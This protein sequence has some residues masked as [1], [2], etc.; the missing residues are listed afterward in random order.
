[1]TANQDEQEMPRRLPVD[2]EERE[3]RRFNRVMTAALCSAML[4]PAAY[5]QEAPQ[6]EEDNGDEPIIV[7]ATLR[8]MDVQDIPL[9][10]TAVAPETL[11]REGV[12]DIKTLSSISPSFN[13]QSSQTET[14]G[15]SIKIR[16]VGTTGNNTGLESSVGV[17]IDGVYQSRPGV[18]LGDLV[19]LERLEILRGPQGTLFG[20]NTSAGALNIT[21][22]RPNLSEFE[23]FVNASYGNYNFMNVQA[24]VS[25]P[26][27]QD[28]AAA[29]FSG[30]WRK[31]DGFLKSTT[32][33]ESNNRDR[34]MLRGQL[35]IEPNADVSIR[36]LGDY[37]KVDENCCDAVVMRETE[38]QPFFAFHGLASDGIDQVGRPALQ[39]LS[40]NSQL[41]INTS[42]QWG[43]SG[44]LKWDF[45]GAKLTYIGSYRDFKSESTQESD[46]T[47]LAIFT[48]GRNGQNSR[49][50]ILPN[51]DKIKTMTQELRLQGTAFDDH[52]DWLIGGFYSDEK[53]RALGSLTAGA[54]FQRAV[55]AGNFANLAGV[56]PLF[57]LTAFGNA[58][59]PVNINGGYAENLFIQNAKSFSVFTHNVINFTDRLSLTL[60]ARYVDEKKTAS[61]DQLNSTNAAC[62][63]SVTGVLNGGVP[64]PLRAGLV[65]LNCFPFIA[66]VTLTAPA[67]LGGGLA[68]R[69]LP[70][71]REWANTFKDNEITYTAQVGYKP[72]DDLLL[73]A[74]Y[75]HGF[76]SGGFNL[77]PTAANLSNST[78][79]LTT[80]AAPIYAD[81]R[82]KSE[83]VDQ[84]EAGV[85]ATIGGIK[86]NLAVFQMDMADFQVLEFTGV[87]FTTF[88]VNSAKSTGVELELFGRL[89]DHI[90]G[91]FSAT[92][93][94]ARYPKNCNVGV[95]ADVLASVTR[96][97]G[98][99]LTNAP[100][101]AG[102][103]GLTYDGPLNSSGWGL[104]VNG[105]INYSSKRRTSTLPLDNNNLPIPFDYQNAY[106]KMNAR[107]GLT[108]PDEQFTFELWGTNINNEK[109]RGITANTPLRGGVGTRSRIGF[110]EEPRM[111][112]LTV[113][114]KF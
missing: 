23:G 65:G 101:L 8:A 5:A 39:N 107:I 106:F 49:P 81:P 22:K 52:L 34:Y 33:A 47:S 4:V 94:N 91:N 27:A 17:F 59:V 76:K 46:F 77:D 44:E 71:P 72:N 41:F 83:K 84:I 95:P 96:L 63:A 62:Q 58:G 100:K 69:Y 21:T 79:V 89:S 99:S 75:S 73:Y 98:D 108:T 31:R 37:S 19:D 54:D 112:G 78:A 80:G 103:M 66:P 64:A 40:T 82:F 113:R 53:I 12:S 7:T 15:T 26:L 85:K 32:G 48:A 24:G 61:F 14:Q 68:S 11:E 42:T 36:I 2:V 90:T 55:S 86:A 92:Y 93:A 30:T 29:R 6:A 25:I 88:N 114:A 74:G 13:I 51:G 50:G 60:G 38:L 16:G 20:R 70:L 35:Y 104:L 45:G 102:V 18:A 105:S 3:M 87:Q 97:C 109:T 110:V 43:M 9:A 67:A 10:V 111:Y 28:V 57:T 56:N 1:M